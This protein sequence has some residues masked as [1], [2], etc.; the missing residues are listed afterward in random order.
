MLPEFYTSSSTV[1]CRL[2]KTS[3]KDYK[4]VK[5]KLLADLTSVCDE[6]GAA[7]LIDTF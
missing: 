7:T 4:I 3:K 5:K 1:R 6:A 2:L